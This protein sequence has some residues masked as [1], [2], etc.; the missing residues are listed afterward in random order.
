MATVLSA[1]LHAISLAC[2]Y[3]KERGKGK[4]LVCRDSLSFIRAIQYTDTRN[5]LVKQIQKK[6]N[7]LVERGR[8][9]VLLWMPGYAGIELN[10]QADKAAKEAASRRAEF[11]CIPHS[12]WFPRI[13]K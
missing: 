12:D 13:K 1:E 4:Y 10:E 11:T 5:I 8:E 9:I 3:A 6:I 2:L 7:G